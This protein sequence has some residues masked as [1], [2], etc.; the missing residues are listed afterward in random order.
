MNIWAAIQ[1]FFSSIQLAEE[2]IPNWFVVCMGF[3]TV[4][5]GLICII[6]ICKIMGCFFKNKTVK[7]SVK[8]TEVKQNIENR[9]EITAA[10]SAA[11]AEEMGE[12]VSAIKILSLKKL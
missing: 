12:D 1:S 8:A 5:V 6:I 2:T 10:I 4:F 7:K 11:I 9:G 3:G